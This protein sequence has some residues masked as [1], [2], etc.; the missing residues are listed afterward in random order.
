[1][2]FILINIL[3]Y[4]ISVIVLYYSKKD[5]GNTPRYLYKNEMARLR[6]KVYIQGKRYEENSTAVNQKHLLFVVR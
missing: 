4:E 6:E 1:M 5:T 3:P 2:G